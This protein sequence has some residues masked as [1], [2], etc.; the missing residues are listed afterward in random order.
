MF[1]R[2]GDGRGDLR[3]VGSTT[4]TSQDDMTIWVTTSPDDTGHSLTVDTHE[5]VWV[6]SRLHSV[7]GDADTTVGTVLESDRESGSRG[8][9]TMK[10]RFGCSGSNSSPS[11]T[12]GDE[13]GSG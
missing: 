4:T 9:F 1:M 8:E 5:I 10:L 13:L 7:N 2:D 3:E 6:R 11:D 12:I